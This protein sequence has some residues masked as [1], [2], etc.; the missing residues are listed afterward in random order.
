MGK[1]IS[2]TM[3]AEALVVK[4]LFFFMRVFLSTAKDRNI[5]KIGNIV[6]K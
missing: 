5:K 4:S 1:N 3:S 6:L 2:L